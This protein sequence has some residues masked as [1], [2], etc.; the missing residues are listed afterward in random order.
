MIK[1]VIIFILC[2]VILFTCMKIEGPNKTTSQSK[3]KTRPHRPSIK[4]YIVRVLIPSAF[5]TLTLFL[6]DKISP[7]LPPWMGGEESENLLTGDYFDV[8]RGV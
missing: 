8:E 5:I 1:Y 6:W 2:S 3:S 4:T 7:Q